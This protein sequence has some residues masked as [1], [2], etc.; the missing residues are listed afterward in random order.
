MAGFVTLV[1]QDTMVFCSICMVDY[2]LEQVQK[3]KKCHCLY[4]KDCLFDYLKF[5]IMVGAYEITCPDAKCPQN[6]VFEK[7]LKNTLNFV[8][9]WKSALIQN[10]HG[11]RSLIVTMFAIGSKV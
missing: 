9:M 7:S 3:I 10:K 1:R 6:G 4:C 5:E 2:D 8:S 11:A